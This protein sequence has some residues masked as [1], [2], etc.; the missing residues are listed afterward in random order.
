MMNKLH[1]ILAVLLIASV[2]GGAFGGCSDKTAGPAE[3]E[4]AGTASQAAPETEPEPEEEAEVR[5]NL[6][7]RDFEARVFRVVTRSAPEYPQFDAYELVAEEQN[8]EVLNDAI[9]KRGMAVEDRFDLRVD[10]EKVAEPG[11]YTMQ[12]VRSG[13]SSVDYTVSHTANVAQSV[14]SGSFFDLYQ[15]EYFE[16]DMPW[17]HGTINDTCS[18]C[19]KLFMTMNDYLLL[20]KQQSYCLFFNK[21]MAS[22]YGLRDY[23]EAVL[24]GTWTWDGMYADLK[25]VSAD[26]DGDGDMDQLDRY[27]FSCQYGQMLAAVIGCDVQYSGKDENDLP[28]LVADS[29]KHINAL[30]RVSSVFI[31]KS[32]SL[33]A[34]DYSVSES[35]GRSMWDIPLDTFYAG[36]ALFIG[37]VVR[38]APSII[39]NCDIDFGI[40]PNPKYDENQ[41]DYFTYSEVGNSTALLIP[42]TADL[43]D[44]SFVVEALS[45]ES[46]NTVVPAYYEVTVKTKYSP[47][48][49][50]STVLDLMFAH[51]RFDAA[52]L[53]SWMNISEIYDSI[54]SRKENVFASQYASRAKVAKKTI[55]KWVANIE[56]IENGG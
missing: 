19:G 35:T 9:Y 2:L 48:P 44:V 46:Y 13:D 10:Q 17:W 34:N 49:N 22:D 31:D 55:D 21:N 51:H 33:L 54:L 45:E 40:L 56:K 14:T 50:A 39:A 26:A 52:L 7:E 32:V 18:F 47:D 28:V 37:G 3:D 23:Y 4:T 12:A 16:F 24:D 41:T 43:S 1:R 38:Y 42:V 30:D 15:G 11:S 29:E 36:R 53:Y 5:G 6:P 25:V 27:G 8:G 20:Y